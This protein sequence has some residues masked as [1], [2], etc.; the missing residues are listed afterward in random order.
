[1]IRTSPHI[2]LAGLGP[3]RDLFTKCRPDQVWG[4][5]SFNLHHPADCLFNMHTLPRDSDVLHDNNL[6]ASTIKSLDKALA[7]AVPVMSCHAWDRYPNI[8][9]YP[10]DAVVGWAGI[11][12]FQC[13]AAYAIA[14]A[15]YIGVRRIDLCGITGSENYEHQNPCLSY[16][17]GRGHGMGV[18]IRA[19]GTSSRLLRT[20][21]GIP[22]APVQRQ[23][24]YGY[25]REPLGARAFLEGV[26]NG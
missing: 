26:V 19:N 2:V 13:T 9:A 23:T 11:D 15:L 22:C 17:I 18:D 21:T 3:G 7:D 1:M 6:Y 25:D 8:H 4:I 24:R 5:N 20:D 16:W 14:Y 12:Y 10:I